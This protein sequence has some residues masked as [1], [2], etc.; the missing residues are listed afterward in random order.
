MITY[1]IYAGG[2]WYARALSEQERDGIIE[3]ISY[4]DIEVAE[5]Y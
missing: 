5:V 2:E 3:E 1:E 4:A